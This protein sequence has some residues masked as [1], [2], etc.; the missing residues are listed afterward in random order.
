MSPDY[1]ATIII[2]KI[3]KT[4]SLVFISI[5]KITIG[6]EL[7]T[8]IEHDELQKTKFNGIVISLTNIDS[9]LIEKCPNLGQGKARICSW[10]QENV[11]N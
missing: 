3:Y 10:K 9:K 1:L 2:N 11:W 7:R 8:S 5:R 4:I 6:T